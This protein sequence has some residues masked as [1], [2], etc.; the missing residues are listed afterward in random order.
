MVIDSTKCK[1]CIFRNTLCSDNYRDLFGYCGYWDKPH[2]SY[3]NREGQGGEPPAKCIM[4]PVDAVC[5][6]CGEC[7]N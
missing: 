5:I 3:T 2:D 1:G 4:I 6:G 7:K